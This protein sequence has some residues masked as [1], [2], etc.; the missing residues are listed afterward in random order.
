MAVAHRAGDRRHEAEKS[1]AEDF[2]LLPQHIIVCLCF[3]GNGHDNLSFLVHTV[4]ILN[5]FRCGSRVGELKVKQECFREWND[6]V[7]CISLRKQV[8]NNWLSQGSTTF[9]YSS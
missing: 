9:S 3:P 6:F 8:S 4:C 2:L 5:I 7:E 1:L